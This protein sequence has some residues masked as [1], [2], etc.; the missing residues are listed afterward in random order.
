MRPRGVGGA[1]CSRPLPPRWPHRRGRRRSSGHSWSVSASAV[2]S[3]S[4]GPRIARSSP[5]RGYRPFQ[6]TQGLA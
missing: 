2:C 3:R 4:C 1:D 5:L 6:A